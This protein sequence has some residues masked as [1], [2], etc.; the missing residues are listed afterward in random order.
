MKGV[1]EQE[2][3]F[4]GAEEVAKL[5]NVSMTTGYRIIKNLNDQLKA[6][7]YIVVAGKVSRRYFEEKVYM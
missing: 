4:I 5:L 2:N 1:Q 7:G 3:K 6:E